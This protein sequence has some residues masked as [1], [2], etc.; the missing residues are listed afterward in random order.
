VTKHVLDGVDVLSPGSL[1]YTEVDG[2]GVCVGRT[3][4]GDLFAIEDECPH[5]AAS[6][7]DGEL[8]GDEVECPLHASRF[9]VRTGEVRCLPARVPARTF[10][11]EL[12]DGVAWVNV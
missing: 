3:A 5:E 9:D 12:V 10:P 1:Q 7:S 6:L 2:V 8:I 4:S 11:V